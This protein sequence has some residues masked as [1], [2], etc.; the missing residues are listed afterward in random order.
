A[1]AE[2]LDDLAGRRSDTVRV[3]HVANKRHG[4]S[5][6]ALGFLYSARAAV[7]LAIECHDFRAGLGKGEGDP[8]ADTA[9]RAGD[10]AH[11]LAQSEP[12]GH[13]RSIPEGGLTLP[14]AQATLVS[15]FRSSPEF[16]AR[17]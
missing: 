15:R 17:P 10:D 2:R 11:L 5:A 16:A 4:L 14:C 12:V 7:G 9:R 1:A 6:G 8:A 3:G 13:F